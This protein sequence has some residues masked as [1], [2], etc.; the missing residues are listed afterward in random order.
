MPLQPDP[1]QESQPAHIMHNPPQTRKSLPRNFGNTQVLQKG[2]EDSD[3]DMDMDDGDDRLVSNP[4]TIQVHRICRLF[5]ARKTFPG[6]IVFSRVCM[7]IFCPA[8]L[9]FF[10]INI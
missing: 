3:V 8:L 7:L 2:G 4:L 6:G 5:T 9:H 1:P 10:P